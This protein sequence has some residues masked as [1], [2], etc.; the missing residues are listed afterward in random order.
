[1]EGQDMSAPARRWTVFARYAKRR[2]MSLTL[3]QRQR[4]LWSLRRGLY[5]LGRPG[6]L[7][8]GLQLSCPLF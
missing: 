2:G 6:L 1:M 4:L 7:A 5:L 3:Q 8:V